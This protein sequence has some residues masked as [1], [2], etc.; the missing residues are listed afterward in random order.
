MTQ[1]ELAFGHIWSTNNQ[2]WTELGIISLNVVNRLSWILSLKWVDY[3][4]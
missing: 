4:S 3:L 2:G 1:I